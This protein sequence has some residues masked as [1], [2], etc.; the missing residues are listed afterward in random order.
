MSFISKLAPL[1]AAFAVV[2]A[3]GAVETWGDGDAAEDSV[4]TRT[5]ASKEFAFT[6]DTT[7]FP[8]EQPFKTITVVKSLAEEPVGGFM[9]N[10]NVLVQMQETTVEGY[11]ATTKDELK[12]LGFEMVEIKPID[13][14]G[15]KC[16]WGEYKGEMGGVELHFLALAI[17]L[18][19]RVILAT[20]TA[21]EK[22]FDKVEAK[23]EKAVKSL[24]L[25]A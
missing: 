24:N 1:L 11:M 23:L 20:G 14:A 8:V 5:F 17:V 6:I 25:L 16:M 12:G 22:D 13:H 7:D 2:L 15:K 3:A 21:A 4:K 18:E 10:V 19:D 9:P